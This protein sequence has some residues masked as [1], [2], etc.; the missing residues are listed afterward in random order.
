MRSANRI[1]PF[2]PKGT[3]RNN[4]HLFHKYE[5]R[6][7]IYRVLGKVDVSKLAELVRSIPEAVWQEGAARAKKYRVHR[8]TATI[9]LRFGADDMRELKKESDILSFTGKKPLEDLLDHKGGM[10][11]NVHWEEYRGVIEPIL[12]QIQRFYE[13]KEGLW[14]RV[15]LVRL[16]HK[17]KVS[18]HRDNGLWMRV[19]RRIHV[20][21]ITDTNVKFHAALSAIDI[22]NKKDAV[23][24]V[25][26]PG[27]VVELN[28][29][30]VHYVDNGSKR[31][32]VHL[33]CDYIPDVPKELSYNEWRC[34]MGYFANCDQ[35]R[36]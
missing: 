35:A 36:R 18:L 15:L 21:V 3:G 22:R 5:A 13:N 14:L 25:Q 6:E 30:V 17:Q 31:D 9:A 11:W 28:N 7:E 34:L 8:Y 2:R 16:T 4:S 1:A 10:H 24:P 12:R 33:I 20:P 26:H 29:A 23:L 32:R 27:A 19:S